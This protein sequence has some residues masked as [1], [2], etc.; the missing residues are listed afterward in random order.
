MHDKYS[1]NAAIEIDGEPTPMVL[2]LAITNPIY[3][4]RIA[5]YTYGMFLQPII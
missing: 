2:V 5:T 4:V 1:I 3:I